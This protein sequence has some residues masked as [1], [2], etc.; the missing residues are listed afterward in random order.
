MF[1]PRI[2]CFFCRW[3]TYAGADLAGTS[4]KQYPPNGVAVRVNCSCR[5]DPQHILWA[6][7]EGADGVLIGG[8]HPNDCHYQDGNYKTM[9]RV[10]L[11]K[12][13]LAQM[14]IE[15]DRLR[16]EWISAAE[17]EKLVHVMSDFVGA[18]RKLGPLDYGPIADRVGGRRAATKKG[19]STPPAKAAAKPAPKKGAAA[20]RAVTAPKK[21]VRK[22]AARTAKPAPR[23]PAPAKKTAKKTPKT[24]KKRTR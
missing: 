20:K 12:P 23:R 16:L 2:V 6:F 22:T 7:H 14:G 21:Q 4:R 18:V 15:P 11:L 13:L 5:V 8:C 10:A 17:G 9:R 24:A 1:E 3:C 19:P